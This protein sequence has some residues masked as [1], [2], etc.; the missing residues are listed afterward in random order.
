MK[1]KNT[2]KALCIITALA[3]FAVVAIVVAEY[4]IT[5]SAKEKTFDSVDWIDL[6][7]GDRFCELVSDVPSL[8]PILFP[9][10]IDFIDRIAYDQYSDQLILTA[11]L[12]GG[13]RSLFSYSESA[14]FIQLWSDLHEFSNGFVDIMRGGVIFARF[15]QPL[16]LLRSDDYAQSWDVITEALVNPFWTIEEGEGGTL[17]APAWSDP[18]NAP[19]LYRSDDYGISWTVWKDFWEIFPEKSKQYDLQDDRRKLRHLHDIVVYGGVILLGTGDVEGQTLISRDGGDTW[20]EITDNGFTSHLLDKDMGTVILGGDSV[21]GHGISTYDFDSG[22]YKRKWDPRSCEWSGHFFSML[23]KGDVYYASAQIE[24]TS[25]LK[26]GVLRSLDGEYWQP[27]YEFQA[28]EG[29]DHVPVY[30]SDG[31]ENLIF[32]SL[33]GALYQFFSE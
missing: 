28:T 18:L 29:D 23:E 11:A 2:C 3:L 19:Y 26:Y 5:N 33:D 13:G 20:E 17:F 25:G 15:D 31:P 22:D 12:Q 4:A 1:K 7:I 16:V 27:F 8:D 30:L 6:P 9:D 14:G 21:T 24:N 10:E 32:L